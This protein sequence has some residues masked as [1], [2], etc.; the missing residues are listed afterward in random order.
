MDG[1]CTGQ[2]TRKPGLN[3]FNWIPISLQLD[4]SLGEFLKTVGKQV[5]DQGLF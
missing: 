4:P 2:I 3:H 1:S 5:P